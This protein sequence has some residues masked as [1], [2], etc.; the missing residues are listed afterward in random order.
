MRTLVTKHDSVREEGRCHQ[1]YPG[2][3]AQ[4][5]VDQIR[6]RPTT[7]ARRRR[8]VGDENSRPGGA[9]LNEDRKQRC[10]DHS[11]PHFGTDIFPFRVGA[12]GACGETAVLG[13]LGRSACQVHFRPLIDVPRFLLTVVPAPEAREGRG[14]SLLDCTG[15]LPPRKRS[16]IIV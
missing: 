16:C 12:D 8:Q 6:T 10:Y 13:H 14:E 5:T 2:H 15:E 1:E 7:Q 11:M 4:Y 3:R 9:E